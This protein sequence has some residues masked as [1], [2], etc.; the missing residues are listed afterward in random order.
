MFVACQFFR[1]FAI[2]DHLLYIEICQHFS[3]LHKQSNLSI[4]RSQCEVKWH[5]AID[6]VSTEGATF[7]TGRKHF[8][9]FAGVGAPSRHT[10]Q[11][12]IREF[13]A[14]LDV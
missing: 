4:S 10:Q 13:V 14:T 9:A 8:L 7:S 1:Y 2:V 3:L 5:N 6:R 11:W 12:A